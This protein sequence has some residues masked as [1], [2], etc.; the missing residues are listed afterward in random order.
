MFGLVLIR[1]D[2]LLTGQDPDVHLVRLGHK[3]VVHAG[4]DGRAGLGVGGV[5]DDGVHL[6]GA[7]CVVVRLAEVYEG[8][9]E[10]LS[11]A[12]CEA[13][14]AVSG[15]TARLLSHPVRQ[16]ASRGGG[17]H[18]VTGRRAGCVLYALHWK[19]KMGH[20]HVHVC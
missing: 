5:P 4:T 10:P 20:I 16:V 11:P 2:L 14:G 1:Y 18:K 7:A 8:H 15:A 12:G 19:V 3:A 13:P 6:A 17:A 9:P